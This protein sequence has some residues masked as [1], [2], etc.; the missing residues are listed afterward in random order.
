MNKEVEFEK[1]LK[2]LG[3]NFDEQN[4]L[5]LPLKRGNDKFSAEVWIEKG[6]FCF[7]K[8]FMRGFDYVTEKE[9]LDNFNDLNSSAKTHWLEVKGKII[10]A[11]YEVRLKHE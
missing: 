5:V 10:K 11:G 1:H 3:F 2:T 8:H 7:G 4:F 6:L 9:I